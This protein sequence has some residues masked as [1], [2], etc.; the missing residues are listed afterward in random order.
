T[1]APAILN[2][3]LGGPSRTMPHA[4]TTFKNFWKS[5]NP[6]R[7]TLL[8]NT[9]AVTV[10]VPLPEYTAGA[11]GGSG[12]GGGIDNE[13]RKL[14]I[15]ASTVAFNTASGGVGFNFVGSAEPPT[16]SASIGMGDGGGVFSDSF[17]SSLLSSSIIACNFADTTEF[18]GSIALRLDSLRSEEHTSELQ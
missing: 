5:E 6:N 11:D 9:L 12:R 18:A 1:Y 14:T 16:L 10:G 13:G 7:P 3:V 17:S 8:A 4:M 2:D 15:V